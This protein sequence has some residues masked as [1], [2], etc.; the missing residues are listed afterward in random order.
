MRFRRQPKTSV[1]P[2][3]FRRGQKS[4][5]AAPAFRPADLLDDPVDRVP[6]GDPLD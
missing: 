3:R 6:V 2:C 5:F 4:S 1:G